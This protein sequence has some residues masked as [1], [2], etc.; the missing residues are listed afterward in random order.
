MVMS[1]TLYWPNACKHK[2][3][4]AVL[5]SSNGEWQPCLCAQLQLAWGIAERIQ[6][7]CGT[8]IL[9]GEEQTE[10]GEPT[11]TFR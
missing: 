3:L 11:C 2:R 9:V 10:T 5:E 8:E 7:R 1:E 6:W 4:V